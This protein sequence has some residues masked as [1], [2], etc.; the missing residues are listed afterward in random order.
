MRKSVLPHFIVAQL[1]RIKYLLYRYLN[2][3]TGYRN[4]K[5]GI[6]AIHPSVVFRQ[7]LHE[8]KKKG[9]Q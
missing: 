3:T 4:R 6:S 1:I 8:I 2:K 5:I 7:E 9:V